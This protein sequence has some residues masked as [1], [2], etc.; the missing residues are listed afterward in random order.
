M[1]WYRHPAEESFNKPQAAK[2]LIRLLWYQFEYMFLYEILI[3]REQLKMFVTSTLDQKSLLHKF[4]L[5]G[6]NRYAS[7]GLHSAML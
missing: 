3:V 1:G 5:G 6:V 7:V 4:K 2:P